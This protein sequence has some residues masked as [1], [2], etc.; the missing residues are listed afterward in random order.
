MLHIGHKG[1]DSLLLWLRHVLVS[2]P[3][4]HLARL[5]EEGKASRR[6]HGVEEEFGG[7]PGTGS[8]LAGLELFC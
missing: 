8:Y 4:G 3:A 5:I 1:I 7:R 2:K 6:P